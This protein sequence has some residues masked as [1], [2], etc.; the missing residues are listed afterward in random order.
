MRKLEPL[1]TYEPDREPRSQ[2]AA[3]PWRLNVAGKVEVLLITSRETHRWVIPKGWPIK[4][5]S[6]AKSAA[7]E[8]FEEAGV[9]GKISKRPVGSYA[10]DKR[11]KSGRLQRVRV[12]VYALYV[13]TEADAYLELGQR[14][15]L[16]LSLSEAARRVDEPELM[17][18]LATFQ[19]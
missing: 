9:Q 7:Q 13:E 12:A 14:E 16:W 6:S 18:L 4:G 3:L 8:A 15:K 1:S 10:Y 17:V 2:F 19:P 11:L 5:K